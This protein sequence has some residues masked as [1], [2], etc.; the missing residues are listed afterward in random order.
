MLIPDSEFSR[1]VFED[2]PDVERFGEDEM[3]VIPD[4]EYVS[5]VQI[6]PW[7]SDGIERLKTRLKERPGRES[8]LRFSAATQARKLAVL[9]RRVVRRYGATESS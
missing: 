7:L 4:E 1:L 5:G 3:F 8:R 2:E 9:Y 6:G